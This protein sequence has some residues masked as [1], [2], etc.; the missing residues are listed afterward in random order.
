M[1]VVIRPKPPVPIL[2]RVVQLIG[3]AALVFG[4]WILI[5]GLDCEGL[6]CLGQIIGVMG[7]GWGV[8][9]VLAGIR[10]MVG[11]ICLIGA[12][13]LALL[14]AFATPWFSLPFLAVA[15]FLLKASKDKLKDYYRNE[16]GSE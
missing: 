2:T 7:V 12:I 9:A 3:A 6:E 15:F 16:K 11:F 5:D 1:N 10:N 8:V 13:V 14:L 4:T